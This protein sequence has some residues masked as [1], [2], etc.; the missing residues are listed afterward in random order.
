MALLQPQDAGNLIRLSRT[1][2]TDLLKDDRSGEKDPKFGIVGGILGLLLLAGG[3]TVQGKEKAVQRFKN[4]YRPHMALLQPQ[5]AV[6]A[7]FLP[8]AARARPSLW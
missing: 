2:P 3:Y 8:A 7:Q 5:D 4:Q 1:A 6:K